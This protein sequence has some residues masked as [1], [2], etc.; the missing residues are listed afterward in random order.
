[1]KQHSIRQCVLVIGS[2]SYLGSHLC[3][4]FIK[5]GHDVLC[6][7]NFFTVTRANITRLLGHPP[8]EFL[9]QRP[10]GRGQ[11]RVSAV[12]RASS[13]SSRQTARSGC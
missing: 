8:F 4:R 9:R 12:V 3:D 7:D 2:A 13:T 10:G 1:M 5:D 11:V 6:V